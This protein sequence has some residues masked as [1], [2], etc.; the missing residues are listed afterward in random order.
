MMYVTKSQ[1]HEII[2][3]FVMY[4]SHINQKI[5]LHLSKICKWNCIPLIQFIIY[6]IEILN[7]FME[8]K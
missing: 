7:L 2:Q 5:K 3:H 4:V 1:K 6:N 8:E